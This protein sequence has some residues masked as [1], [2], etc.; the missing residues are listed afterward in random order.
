MEFPQDQLDELHQ[1]ASNVQQHQEGGFTYLLLLNLALPVGCVP[2]HVDAL[3][4]PM[5]RDGYPSR[6]FFA[7]RITISANRNWGEWH[8]LGRNWSAIS[9]HFEEPNLRLAQLVA[10]HLRALR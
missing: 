2:D 8:I 5:S 6:L 7:Q 3:L 9:L 10:V 4:C 1:L